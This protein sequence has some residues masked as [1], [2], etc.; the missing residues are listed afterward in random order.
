MS[1]LPKRMIDHWRMNRAKNIEFNT[2]GLGLHRH[3][4]EIHAD[5]AHAHARTWC[6]H[7]KA[8][9]NTAL[10]ETRRHRIITKTARLASS[11]S[12]IVL[13]SLLTSPSAA[14]SPP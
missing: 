5:S 10:Y 8:F 2:M 7:N 6:K 11:C 14:Q 4:D 9:S 3:A 1:Q 13:V 12:R